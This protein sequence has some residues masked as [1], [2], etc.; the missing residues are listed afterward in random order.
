MLKDSCVLSQLEEF[1]V[2]QLTIHIFLFG[3]I[4]GSCT[5]I[6]LNSSDFKPLLVWNAALNFSSG[7]IK[8][9]VL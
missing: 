1:Q 4:S 7:N 5:E 6:I 3:K 9:C 2:P 8:N